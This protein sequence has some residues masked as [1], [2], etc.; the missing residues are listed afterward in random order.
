M[1]AG[2]KEVLFVMV[3][4]MAISQAEFFWSILHDIP[5]ELQ[6]AMIP[7][8]SYLLLRPNLGEKLRT[9]AGACFMISLAYTQ[10]WRMR[11]CIM[12]L[13]HKMC[14][15]ASSKIPGSGLM[16]ATHHSVTG[17]PG[18]LRTLLGRIVLLL[19]S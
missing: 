3:S 13:H 11:L 4:E 16:G 18:S 10:P 15:L 5:L 12:Y 1:T 8:V 7:A 14:G 2:S 17:N 19:Y 6:A 9:I